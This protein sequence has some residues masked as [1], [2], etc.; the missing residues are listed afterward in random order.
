MT[1]ITTKSLEESGY[2]KS[3]DRNNLLSKG[4]NNFDI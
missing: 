3:K 1:K 2:K 4:N